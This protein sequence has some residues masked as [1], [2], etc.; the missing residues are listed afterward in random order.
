MYMKALWWKF[1]GVAILIYVVIAGLA[2]PLKPGIVDVK[3]S[4]AIAGKSVEMQVEGY[5]TNFDQANTRAWLELDDVGYLTA[6]EVSPIDYNHV[7]LIF[8]L[9]NA[10]PQG[11]KIRKLDLVLHSAEDG[12]SILPSALFVNTENA[13]IGDEGWE[14]QT[15]EGITAKPGVQFPY[16]PILNETVRNTF[17]HIPLWFSMFIMLMI[18][19]YYSVRYLLKNDMQFDIRATAIVNVAI[20]FGILGIITGSIWAR[21]TWGTFWT[22]DVKLNMS[23]IAM[24]IYMAS[25]ILRSSIQ[26]VDRRAKLSAAYNIFAFVAL[27]PLVFVIPRLTDSLH[28]GNGGN[29]ALGGE[30]MENT[31]RMVFYPAIIGFTLLGL[32]L[33]TLLIRYETIKDKWLSRKI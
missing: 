13:Q 14:L 10:F 16:R 20:L 12:E 4:D 33:A 30:D 31:L 19:L 27:I 29:P 26:D 8:D 25:I 18:S 2:W 1:L 7:K 23:T 3:S 15:L 11:D 9:P 21:F 22:T 6:K 28:P 17:F 5:N 32:W 24:L